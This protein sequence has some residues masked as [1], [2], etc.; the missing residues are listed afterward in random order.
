MRRVPAENRGN[1]GCT[2]EMKIRP[3][4]VSPISSR[5]MSRRKG[6]ETDISAKCIPFLESNRSNSASISARINLL[7]VCGVRNTD[8]LRHSHTLSNQ[9]KSNPCGNRTGSRSTLLN[10]IL[11][12]SIV[13]MPCVSQNTQRPRGRSHSRDVGAEARGTVTC[14]SSGIL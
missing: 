2:N 13:I 3:I 5:G 9:I 6:L 4:S 14:S 11:D 10:T 12:C 7:I 8:T 1:D